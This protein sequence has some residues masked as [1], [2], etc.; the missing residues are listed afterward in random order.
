MMF[1]LSLASTVDALDK[2]LRRL[3]T[4]NETLFTKNIELQ[5]EVIRQTERTLATANLA[6]GYLGVVQKLLETSTI[7]LDEYRALMNEVM[8]MYNE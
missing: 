4:E 5:R 1:G 6:K 3:S 8:E 7:P 2:D